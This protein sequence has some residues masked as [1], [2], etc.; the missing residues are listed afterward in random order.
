MPQSWPVH[1]ASRTACTGNRPGEKPSPLGEAF[2]TAGKRSAGAEGYYGYHYK[3]LAKQ[4]ASAPG[5]A[6]DYQVR[7]KL[8]GGFAVIAWPVRY[9]QTGVKTF[10]VSHAGEV[11]ER[12][13]GSDTAK[14]AAATT[15]FDPGPG[16]TKVA[17]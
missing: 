13:L 11:F 4:G 16:W 7:G 6:F 8:F 2:L 10:M 15:S 14:K 9:G 5:G 12:D 17:P 1:P 3:L